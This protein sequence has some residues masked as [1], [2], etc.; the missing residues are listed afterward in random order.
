MLQLEFNDSIQKK[1][2]EVYDPDIVKSISFN[3]EIIETNNFFGY[4]IDLS[5]YI[6]LE[7]IYIILGDER[8]INF[9]N[10]TDSIKKVIFYGVYTDITQLSKNIKDIRA[11]KS[12]YT[13]KDF[14]NLPDE[15]EI[16]LCDENNI[17]KLNNLPLRLK[18]LDCSR[19]KIITLDYLPETLEYLWCS[20]NK[21]INLDNLPIGLLYLDCQY[22][23]IT[24]INSLPDTLV[25]ILAKSNHIQ[26]INKLPKSLTK[27]DFTLNPLIS[28]PKCP[29]PIILLNYSLD[30]EKASY[31]D[32][33]VNV[34]HKLMYGGYHA[35]K[36]T[37]YGLGMI[38]VGTIC[39]IAY[40]FAY[41]YVKLKNI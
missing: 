22:N 25:E 10:Y 26:V 21:L 2:E 31:S 41:T 20:Y 28:S 37:T 30:A 7:H 32:K 1:F 5:Q 24:S 27:A 34:G 29:N 13:D 14:V 11:S 23:E 17:N 18:R 4:T 16:L 12:N 35:V 9:I 38:G 19:N 15:L 8:I 3:D 33:A 39:L 40:P 36:Y 6:K